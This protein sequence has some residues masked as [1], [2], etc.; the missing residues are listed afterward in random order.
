MFR[1]WRELRR[2]YGSASEPVAPPT[3]AAARPTRDEPRE[4]RRAAHEHAPGVWSRTR[5][6][7]RLQPAPRRPR[8]A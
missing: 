4:S 5:D 3:S 7:V 8:A 1:N 6:D 2:L